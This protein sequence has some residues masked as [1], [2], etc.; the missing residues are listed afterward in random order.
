MPEGRTTETKRF[1]SLVADCCNENP[2]H[3]PAMKTVVQRLKEIQADVK[4]KSARTMTRK[5][6]IDMS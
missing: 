1:A 4:K 6:C 3:R 5:D 2:Q